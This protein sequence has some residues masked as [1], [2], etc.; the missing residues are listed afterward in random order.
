M[1]EQELR[2][3]IAKHVCC[4]CEMGL[5]D[6]DCAEGS[7]FKKCGVCLD[8]ADALISDGIGDVREAKIE[9]DHF[10]RMWQ[11]ALVELEQAEHRAEVAE[12]SLKD[13]AAD[14]WG[15]ECFC[16]GCSESECRNICGE[17]YLIFDEDDAINC[18]VKNFLEQAEKEL[19]EEEKR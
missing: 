10:W 8:V 14:Y 12:R 1:T 3:K 5:G 11:G 4:A 9:S 19:A 13:M 18:L 6:G 7:D 17:K 15:V 2:E 16:H